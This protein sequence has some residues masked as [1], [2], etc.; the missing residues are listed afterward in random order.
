MWSSA[1]SNLPLPH[2]QRAVIGDKKQEPR[3][4]KAENL[5]QMR[6]KQ[7]LW[8]CQKAL[9]DAKK[10]ASLLH[11]K[12][13]HTTRTVPRRFDFEQINS[14][15]EMTSRGHGPCLAFV[16][17]LL[18]SACNSMCWQGICATTYKRCSLCEYRFH[19][20]ELLGYQSTL[21]NDIPIGCCGRGLVE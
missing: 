1:I 5:K 15:K 20:C 10:R 9:L 3:T 7:R 14:M 11:Q 8:L 17:P 18:K 13:V 2:T 12:V 21:L 4:D 6:P 19:L 16:E